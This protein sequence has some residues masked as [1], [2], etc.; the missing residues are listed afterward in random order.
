MIVG[1]IPADIDITV[2]LTGL[3]EEEPERAMKEF[4]GVVDSE[5]EKG[6][7]YICF[8]HYLFFSVWT[9]AVICAFC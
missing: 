2:Y 7:W 4:Q 6:P 8:V 1:S 5:E 3:K 9:E